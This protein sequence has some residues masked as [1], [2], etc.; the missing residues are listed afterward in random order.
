[1]QCVLFANMCACGG[2]GGG[3]YIGGRGGGGGK[4][5][6]GLG[7]YELA[8]KMM[9]CIRDNIDIIPN[10][11]GLA[12]KRYCALQHIGLTLLRSR[13]QGPRGCLPGEDLREIISFSVLSCYRFDYN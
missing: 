9:I 1:V 13:S 3:L 4:Y 6:F 11:F 5:V 10:Q 8:H 12:N 2:G 7:L